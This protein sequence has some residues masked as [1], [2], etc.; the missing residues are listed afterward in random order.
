MVELFSN[1]LGLTKQIT[2]I[3]KEKNKKIRWNRFNLKRLQ[4]SE[5]GAIIDLSNLIAR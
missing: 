2:K 5:D 4:P 3:Q 1:H